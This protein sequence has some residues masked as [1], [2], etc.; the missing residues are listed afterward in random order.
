MLTFRQHPLFLV[1]QQAFPLLLVGVV[2]LFVRV[3]VVKQSPPY[4]EAFVLSATFI[5]FC[6]NL[7]RWYTHRIVVTD[8]TVEYYPPALLNSHPTI[9]LPLEWVQNTSVAQNGIGRLL[10]FGDL[11]IETAGGRGEIFFRQVF[12]AKQAQFRI[13]NAM[14][15]AYG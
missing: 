5:W 7:R 14:R 4:F 10:Q 13:L 8:T 3:G 11:R 15:K 6:A 12:R 2:F 1:I 9:S